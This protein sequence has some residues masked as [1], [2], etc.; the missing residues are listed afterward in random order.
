MVDP[1]CPAADG[2]MGSDDG[3]Y[4]AG[5]D[6]GVEAGRVQCQADPA[7]CGITVSG[8]NGA[9]QSCATVE[10]GFNLHLPCVM[11]DSEA[12]QADLVYTGGYH[13]AL[14]GAQPLQPMGP[15]PAAAGDTGCAPGVANCVQP[16]DDGSCPANDPNCA[17]A[18]Q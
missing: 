7:S 18:M 10:S 2:S 5:F 3:G 16:T 14:G 8:D 17:A 13:W 11:V 15:D 4:A 6:A 9:L 1:T 12:Y